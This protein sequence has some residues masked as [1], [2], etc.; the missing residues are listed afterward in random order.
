VGAAVGGILSSFGV[1]PAVYAGGFTGLHLLSILLG[2]PVPITP[3]T[4][5]IIIGF[6]VMGVVCLVFLGIVLGS[7][8]GT[9]V[10]VILSQLKSTSDK[11]MIFYPDGFREVSSIREAEGYIA[12]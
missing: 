11:E 9:G 8:F 5:S 12:K 4:Q 7:I 6:G 1:V 3:L 2:N 10:G